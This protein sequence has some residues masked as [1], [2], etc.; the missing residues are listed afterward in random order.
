MESTVGDRTKGIG[1]FISPVFADGLGRMERWE[2]D[3]SDP[4]VVGELVQGAAEGRTLKRICRE[5][6]WPYS[7]VAGWVVEREEVVKA[8]QAARKMWADDLATE[9]VEI[10]DAA[11]SEVGGVPWSKHRTDVR[12]KLAGFLDREK[13]GEQVQHNVSLD[14]FGEMLRRVSER[15]LARLKG[16]QAPERVVSEV[17]AGGAVI[18]EITEI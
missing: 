6:G 9:T 15:N 16:E 12:F 10:A 3:R 14:P 18:E 1:N 4:G 5:R 17:P 8:L 11:P 7:V 13:W 2:R